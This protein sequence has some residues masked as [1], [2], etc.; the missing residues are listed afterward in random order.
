MALKRSPSCVWGK[1]FLDIL[2]L[3]LTKQ[4][5]SLARDDTHTQDIYIYIYLYRIH[6]YVLFNFFFF[7]FFFIVDEARREERFFE[8]W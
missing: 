6:S 8:R 5:R 1:K 4:P 3:P 2:Y 7:F